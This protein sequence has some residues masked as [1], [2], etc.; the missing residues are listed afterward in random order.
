MF[1]RMNPFAR[2]HHTASIS[3]LRPPGSVV[4][5]SKNERYQFKLRVARHY[6]LEAGDAMVDM[7]GVERK[8]EDVTLA[9]IW[10]RSYTNWGEP[11]SNLGMPEDF[12]KDVRNFLLLPRGL[13]EAFDNGDVIL[14]PGLPQLQDDGDT[15]RPIR[16]LVISPRVTDPAVTRLHDT[17]LHIP[18]GKLPYCRLL[19]FFALMATKNRDLMAEHM[20]DIHDAVGDCTD[21]SEGQAEVTKMASRLVAAGYAP[22]PR[23]DTAVVDGSGPAS[24]A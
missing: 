23:R 16:V 7:T 11:C 17:S 5:P 18:S 24:E 13:H 21:S 8:A 20:R 15:A 6:G 4:F 22:P 2:S 10:P 1:D 9:H 19:A 14:L 3:V 12:Y